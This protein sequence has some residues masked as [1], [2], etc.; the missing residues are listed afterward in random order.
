MHAQ[1]KQIVR[2]QDAVNKKIN[3]DW[4]SA[5]YPWHSAAM[6]EAAELDEHLYGSDES[7]F[8]IHAVRAMNAIGWAWWKKQDPD[9]DALSAA[10]EKMHALL[11]KRP[12]EPQPGHVMGPL[13]ASYRLVAVASNAGGP[14]AEA[15]ALSKLE[16]AL[17]AAGITLKP[18]PFPAAAPV[19][20]TKGRTQA[21]I[22]LVDIFHFLVSREIL[23]GGDH[24]AVATR[25]ESH[26]K[27]ALG[28]KGCS[29]NEL[30]PQIAGQSLQANGN[31]FC[32]FYQACLALGM[33]FNQLHTMYI[34]KNILNRFRQD[35]GY[36]QGMYTKTWHGQEDNEV[37]EAM[38]ETMDTAAEDF[39]E[40]L[41]DALT[42][43]YAKVTADS[44]QK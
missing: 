13:E 4:T 39:P 8:W 21:Q 10:I 15:I 28:T 31:R 42:E 16:T 1:L 23:D 7:K 41:Y 5:G 9:V 12:E 43:A 30:V 27:D 26:L 37:L 18:G 44:P 24:D 11:P 32:A 33:D 14:E 22:E 38:V 20:A 19:P 25:I 35:N 2:L 36:K 3:P 34:Q 17:Q 6:A 40:R 29:L